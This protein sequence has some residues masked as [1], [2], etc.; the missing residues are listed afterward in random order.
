M[1]KSATGR[2]GAQTV[3]LLRHGHVDSGD[4]RHYIGRTDLPLSTKGLSQARDLAALLAR[5]GAARIVTSDLDRALQTARIIAAACGLEVE[6]D[7]RLRE[8][9]LGDWDGEAMEAVRRRAPEAYRLRGEDL[10]GFRPPG[11][12][13]FDDLARRVV[14][15][16]EEAAARTSG[17]LIVVAHAGVNRVI[18]AD[19]LGMPRRALLRIGQDYGAVNVIEYPSKGPVVRAMNILCT[20][21]KHCQYHLLRLKTLEKAST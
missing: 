8:I 18:L 5:I 6:T 11:G 2:P 3:Y 19:L 10:A 15:A 16:F 7:P 4:P 17:V 14:P 12:E 9:D 21:P 1:K 20:H 13:S